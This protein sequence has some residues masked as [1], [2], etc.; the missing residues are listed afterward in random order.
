MRRQSKRR[1]HADE[2]WTRA[3]THTNTQKNARTER[4]RHIPDKRLREIHRES[5]HNRF[6]VD[7]EHSNVI[8]VLNDFCVLVKE[9]K[10][11]TEQGAFR[12]TIYLFFVLVSLSEQF[13]FHSTFDERT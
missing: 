7:R 10:Q 2:E 4:H 8:D 11:Q 13:I 6:S 1:H 3:R 5:M 12:K 9:A